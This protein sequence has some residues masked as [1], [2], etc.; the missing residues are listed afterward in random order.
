MNFEHVAFAFIHPHEYS[1]HFGR[2]MWRTVAEHPGIQMLDMGSG[3]GIAGARNEI[4]YA[5]LNDTDCQVLVMADADMAFHPRHVDQIVGLVSREQPIV[6][7]LC[8]IVGRLGILEPTIRVLDP[9]LGGLQ[10]VWD[11]PRDALI[12]VDA[13]GGAFLAVHR[14]VFEKL[15]EE[16]GEHPYPFFAESSHGGFRYSED[17][18]FCIRARRH[19]PVK[20]HTGIKIGHVKPYIY[21]ED[22]YVEQRARL[23]AFGRDH[24]EAEHMARMAIADPGELDAS[25]APNRA[26]RRQM[27]RQR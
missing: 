5:F 14:C 1:A 22:D 3:P 9:E 26:Q 17:T 19:F 2:S 24:V 16:Y 8:F 6:G 7:G 20:V 23:S 4:V 11:Y 27:A 10:T 13:T 21:T 15:L 25:P 12:S 18:T